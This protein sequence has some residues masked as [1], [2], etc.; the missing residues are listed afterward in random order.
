LTL[1]P[2][3]FPGIS[4]A[5]ISA[6]GVRSVSPF[7]A[8]NL[9][10]LRVA[11][12]WIPYRTAEG[13]RVE[14]DGDGPH[15]FGRLRL[16]QA[17]KDGRRYTQRK[18]SKPCGYVVANLLAPLL[19]QNTLVIVEGEKKALSL[20]DAGVAAIGIGGI[21]LAMQDGQLVPGLR[22]VMQGRPDGSRVLFLGDG[23][24][25]LLFSFSREAVKLAK[26]LRDY[27]VALPRIG[28]DGPGKGID[29]VRAALGAEAFNAYWTTLT[30]TAEPVSPDDT[31]EALA[32][33]LF[34]R[35]SPETL[36]KAANGQLS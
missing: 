28:L 15:G 32:V 22:E 6:A 24:T 13:N 23:D 33:R 17:D 29:D 5:T 21:N 4:D 11:G 27:S 9:C 7:E 26:T 20:L 19:G 1:P 34:K 25:S 3:S 36:K 18:G 30:Q 8:E 35:E 10:G 16:F 31:P 14:R 2:P 12:F